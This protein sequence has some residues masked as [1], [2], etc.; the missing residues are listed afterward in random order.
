MMRAGFLL[1]VLAAFC[2]ATLAENVAAADGRPNVVLIVADDLGWADLGCYGSTFH[3][4][5]HL[6]A[7]AGGGCRFVQAY[8]ASPVCSPTRAALLTG[9]H[10]ARLHLTDWLPGRAD[11]PTQRLRRPAIR[12]ALPLEEITLAEL[13]KGAGYAT[14]HIGKWHLGGPGFGPTRQGFD[15]NV[16]GDGSGSPLTYFAPFARAGRAMPGLE[17][18][19]DG[20]YLTDRLT[21]EAERF[22]EQHRTEPFF[23]YLA[24]YA[25]HIPLAAKKELVAKFPSW[26]GTPHGRQENPIYAAMLESV[27]EGLGRL[28][29]KLDELGLAGNTVVIFTSDNGGLATREG[30]H[31]PAT[32]NAPLR[33]G[34]GWLHEGGLRVPLIVRWPGR[35]KPAVVETPVWSGD[36]VP[37]IRAL[38]G[39]TDDPPGDGM[40]LAGLLTER[41]PIAPRAL[42]WHYPHYSNQGGRPGGAIR[43]GDWKLV[44]FFEDGRRELFD[45]RRDPGE[46]TN[47][48]AK[49]PEKVEELAAKLQAWRTSVGAQMP[50]PNPAYSPNPPARDGS[51]TL[52]ARAADVHGVMLRDEPLPHKDTLGFWTMADDWASWEF[53]TNAPTEYSASALI[54]CGKGSGGSMVE[55]RVAGQS[56]R[57]T[58]PETGGFQAF[59]EVELGRITI[60]RPGRHRLEV[61][62]LS[63]PGP[64]VMDLREVRLV[65]K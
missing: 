50:T 15:L 59:Q 11:M 46:T 34:K 41:Q 42:Y 4:T 49:D 23:L 12:Q 29:A 40:S 47:R 9:K 58:V 22:L 39:L 16:A 61:R 38:C 45:L 57:L 28:L 52:R 20:Q 43:E 1:V 26:D 30:P 44:E 62:A 24:H 32:C 55:F 19:P 63:K 36:L 31:T 14:A 48:S 37:T 65:P 3:R 17:E 51:I 2:E 33:E 54:G 8:A 21:L 5:P 18:A 64:A 6:D 25:V 7:M 27:D 35:V 10:P 60:D 13:L 53:D 56:V